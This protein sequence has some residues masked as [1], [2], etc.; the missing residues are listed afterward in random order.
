[1]WSAVERNKKHIPYKSN[2]N[3]ITRFMVG[4]N[5]SKEVEDEACSTFQGLIKEV[6]DEKG[7]FSK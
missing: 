3:L 7:G 6:N 1:M 5:I 4:F 2:A